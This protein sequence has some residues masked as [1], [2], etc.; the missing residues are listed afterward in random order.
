MGK[1]ATIFVALCM[2]MVAVSLA[3][4]SMSGFGLTL[5]DAM[6]VGLG[7]LAILGLLQAVFTRNG[8]EKPQV[9]VEP[10]RS[11]HDIWVRIQAIEERL[12]H[13]EAMMRD[14][15]RVVVEP[16]SEEIAE[17]GGLISQLAEQ[18]DAHDQAIGK[19]REAAITNVPAPE[20]LAAPEVRGETRLARTPSMLNGAHADPLP[21]A[22][23]EIRAEL[24]RAPEPVAV[25]AP[26][27]APAASAPVAAAPAPVTR[28]EKAPR[29][30]ASGSAGTVEVEAVRR[31]MAEDRIEIHLQPIVALPQRRI[32]F[33]EASPRLRDTDGRTRMPMEFL[34]AARAGG[35]APAIDRFVIERGLMIAE[36]L[37]ERGRDL[38]LFV[39]ISP[40]MLADD[41]AFTGLA[42]MLEGW[43]DQAGRIVMLLRQESLS[44]LGALEHET[45]QGLVERG[46]RFGVDHVTDLSFDPRAL[47][48]LGVRYAKVAA[49]VI[50]NPASVT[51]EIHPADVP[52]LL[53]RHGISFIATRVETEATVAD[54]LDFDIAHA[55]GLLFGPPRPV[56][57][58]I[59]EQARPAAP[60]ATVTPLQRG[61]ISANVRPQQPAPRPAL[62]PER[63]GQGFARRV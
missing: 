11:N 13:H 35:L 43:R 40:A 36:R 7:S 9:R 63:Y 46:F 18:I 42:A 34:P 15:A 22:V 55:Q 25:P 44:H 26:S 24:R 12:A 1:S 53:K 5:G 57:S 37:R 6:F 10:G 59:F 39:S 48:E 14:S 17:I 19:L 8:L 54:L 38:G 3:V 47:N 56:R 58:E 27:V 49:D 16:V 28:A 2:V 50:L 31:A 32:L 51:S 29:G 21:A 30:M 61:P 45:L 41:T 62:R 20:S 33:Y 23:S 52:G 60:A 4:I